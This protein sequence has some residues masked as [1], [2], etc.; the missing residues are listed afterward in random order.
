MDKSKVD[1]VSFKGLDTS[2]DDG[3]EVVSYFTYP[4]VDDNTESRIV[5]FLS[6]GIL[7]MNNSLS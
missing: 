6:G 2:I 3:E 7:P 1:F 4:N 5:I